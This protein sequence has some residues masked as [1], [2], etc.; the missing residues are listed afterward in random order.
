MAKLSP[1]VA[2]PCGSGAKY[3]K[4]CRVAHHGRPASTPEALMRSRYTAYVVGF[5]EYIIRT[6]DPDGP[7]WRPVGPWKASID[8]LC[9]STAFVGLAVEQVEPAGEVEGF[10]TFRVQMER[11]G[12]AVTFVERSRFV[13]VDNR[14][15]YHSGT[16]TEA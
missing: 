4:C 7:Q 10:V 15:L 6:T 8:E 11:E 16:P 3:K 5:S 2:C 12:E 9:A 13:K 1:N 14:W